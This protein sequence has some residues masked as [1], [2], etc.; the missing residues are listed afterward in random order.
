MLQQFLL[1]NGMQVPG[2]TTDDRTSA[3]RATIV[4]MPVMRAAVGIAWSL[5]L[6]ILFGGRRGRALLSFAPASPDHR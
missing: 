5:A 6:L 3:L 4:M 1:T 2:M